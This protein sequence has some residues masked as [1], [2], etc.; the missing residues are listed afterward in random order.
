MTTQRN[1]GTQSG[2]K[3]YWTVVFSLAGLYMLLRFAPFLKNAWGERVPLHRYALAML[4]YSGRVLAIFLGLA[5]ALRFFWKRHALGV[6]PDGSPFNPSRLRSP[7]RLVRC[8]EGLL[9]ACATAVAVFILFRDTQAVRIL[10]PDLDGWTLWTVLVTP[11]IVVLITASAHAIATNRLARVPIFGLMA[12]VWVWTIA[13]FGLPTPQMKKETKRQER[14]Q[15]TLSRDAQGDREPARRKAVKRMVDRLRLEDYH[16]S[17]AWF[18][19][20][21]RMI[22]EQPETWYYFVIHAATEPEL[23]EFLDHWARRLYDVPE[24]PTAEQAWDL[25]ERICKEAGD[26]EYYITAGPAGRVMDMLIPVLD[27]DRLIE[28]ATRLAKEN[29]NLP[30]AAQTYMGKWELFFP[31]IPMGMPRPLSYSSGDEKYGVGGWNDGESDAPC[32]FDFAP[33]VHAM[34]RIDQLYDTGKRT[35]V[36]GNPVER[37]VVPTF[38]CYHIERPFFVAN[39]RGVGGPALYDYFLRRLR[40]QDQGQNL[41]LSDLP[42]QVLAWYPAPE[43]RDFRHNYADRLL[44]TAKKM[45]RGEHGEDIS[46]VFNQT[47]CFFLP[48]TP[49]KALAREFWPAFRDMGLTHAGTKRYRTHQLDYLMRYLVRMEPLSRVEDYV[50]C[51][52]KTHPIS[53]DYG[54]S[55]ASQL[56]FLAD[57]PTAKRRKILNALRPVLLDRTYTKEE[58]PQGHP[59]V[60]HYRES[61]ERG[62]QHVWVQPD[63]HDAVRVYMQH[64]ETPQGYT[65]LQKLCWERPEHPVVARIANRTPVDKYGPLFIQVA[66]AIRRCPTP[67]NR[68]ALQRF[69]TSPNRE[70]RKLAREIDTEFENIRATPLE[71]LAG[72]DAGKETK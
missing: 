67:Q 12:V 69:L 17:D 50:E 6:G 32:R 1:E 71:E 55:G 61:L 24:H 30:G 49:D 25:Y 46:S 38:A 43:G 9:G 2:A 27:E 68:K 65:P 47:Q 26:K 23:G 36:G 29:W 59:S 13:S 44:E 60:E 22:A 31:S 10:R 66:S 72:I 33:L 63:D 35:R 19:V 52:R 16:P 3:L 51:W 8:L 45:A 64:A 21:N 41:R 42:L 28:Q 37:I 40:S 53:G 15:F 58:L 14:P 56:R 34:W 54:G 18:A 7:D 4:M 20:A 39:A 57:I 5:L 70:V 62:L 48:Q 11:I